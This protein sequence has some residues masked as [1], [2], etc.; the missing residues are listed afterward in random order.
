MGKDVT[1]C[2]GTIGSGIWR[3]PDGGET[4]TRVRPSRYPE[5]DVRALAVHPRVPHRVYAGTDSGV[6]RSEDR[7]ASWERL[8]SP[9]NAMQTWAL[10]IDPVV[11]DILFAGTKPPAALRARGRGHQWEPLAVGP[12]TERPALVIPRVTGRGGAPADPRTLSGG[13]YV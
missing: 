10:A 7:G 5:N 11:P 3:S 12:A 6:Y 13:V 9:M 8:D 1:I 2:V 4:W